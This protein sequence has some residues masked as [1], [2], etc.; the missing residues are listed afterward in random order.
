MSIFAQHSQADSTGTSLVPQDTS[1]NAMKKFLGGRGVKE[2]IINF[3]AR[4]ITP[5]IHKSV[6]K[7]VTEKAHSFE[8]AVIYRVSVA[9]A[10]MA[11]WVK[12][13]LRYSQARCLIASQQTSVRCW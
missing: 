8:D 1:W 5:A 11:A 2:S 6:S 7:L 4:R 9:A 3:D 10:P 13:N 12:A